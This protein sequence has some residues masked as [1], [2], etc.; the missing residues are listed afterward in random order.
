MKTIN[1]ICDK[2]KKSVEADELVAIGLTA[3]FIRGL[4][5]NLLINSAE[6]DICKTCLKEKGLLIESEQ[7]TYSDDMLHNDKIF[8]TKMIEILEELGV[9]FLE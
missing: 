7:K 3:S 6:K 2:C 4:D 9:A 1:Y 8:E 5:N